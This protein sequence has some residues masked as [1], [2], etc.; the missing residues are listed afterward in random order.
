MTKG[1][2]PPVSYAAFVELHYRHYEMYAH[3][4][5]DDAALAERVVAL[6]LHRAQAQWSWV[7]REDPAAF[8]WR[9]LC[10]MVSLARTLAQ[11]PPSDRLHRA[12]PDRPADAAL[13]HDLLG[14]APAVAAALM[15]LDEPDVRVQLKAARRWSC[16]HTPAG[17][18]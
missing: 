5:L 18:A 16:G 3:A 6:V 2:V 15:G 11:A 8:T 17:G 14:L 13:L 9:A 10:E 1:P 7:L 4:R 12:M